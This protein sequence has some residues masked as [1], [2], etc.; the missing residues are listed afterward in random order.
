[1]S[2]TLLPTLDLLIRSVQGSPVASLRLDLDNGT[3]PTTRASDRPVALDLAALREL[4]VDIT[5]YGQR[6]TEM[7]FADEELR[8]AWENA[9][10]HRASWDRP[11]RCRLDIKG[12]DEAL[13]SLRWELLNNPAQA[14]P[15][16]LSGTLLLTR[17]ID[18]ADTPITLRRRR[19]L[20]ALVAIASPH[21]QADFNL[22]PIDA[23]AQAELARQALANIPVATLGDTTGVPRLSLE[24]L[25]QALRDGFDILYLVCH[26][27]VKGDEGHVLLEEPDGGRWVNAAELAKTIVGQAQRPVLV[28]L[29]VC[30]S[31]GNGDMLS[32]ALGPRLVAGG[33]G[34]VVA[35]QGLVSVGT[36]ERCIPALFRDLHR[37]GN[38]ERAISAARGN[39]RSGTTWWQPTLFSRL[40]DGTIWCDDPPTFD[41]A[42]IAGVEPTVSAVVRQPLRLRGLVSEPANDREPGHASYICEVDIE[43]DGAERCAQQALRGAARW[44]KPQVSPTSEVALEVFSYQN[45]SSVQPAALSLDWRSAYAAGPPAT[46]IWGAQLQPILGELHQMLDA[47]GVRQVLVHQKAALPIAFAL[48]FAFLDRGN[49]QLSVA[50]DEGPPWSVKA[51]VAD[52]PLLEMNIIDG[53]PMAG[54][55]SVEISLA[56]DVRPNV[57]AYLE[58]ADL[59]TAR[60]V[61]LTSP[62]L[63]R[64]DVLG[65]RNFV[66]SAGHARRLAAQLASVILSQKGALARRP[67]AM[68]HLFAAVPFALAVQVGSLLNAGPAVQCYEYERAK[69]GYVRSCR[70]G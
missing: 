18:S 25:D 11:M 9:L 27:T 45:V 28:I 31:A 60:R 68:I 20:R 50:V 34:A 49:V 13:H 15:L 2:S 64:D 59:R 55:V 35:M 1:M 47:A 69:Q 36:I 7:L 56:Q 67:G 41:T 63:L 29:A 38:I 40:R 61:Q 58:A 43:R 3:A 5:A 37:H 42:L 66:R 19:E 52:G 26:G 10:A 14:A 57:D 6:L 22:V 39:L 4:A 33:I 12:P 53:E 48:G 17:L 70:L 44:L 54:D 23:A 51:P 30:A 21:N 65:A 46:E 32:A 24:T 16:A 8:L 62:P